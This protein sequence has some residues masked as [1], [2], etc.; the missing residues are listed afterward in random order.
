MDL[1]I[2]RIFDFCDLETQTK[3]TYCSKFTYQYLKRK[4]ER[5]VE[6]AKK[7]MLKIGDRFEVFDDEHVFFSDLYDSISTRCIIST[8]TFEELRKELKNKKIR[9]SQIRAM[10]LRVG[11]AI[12]KCRGIQLHKEFPK[13]EEFIYNCMAETIPCDDLISRLLRTKIITDI[14]K[15]CPLKIFRTSLVYYIR[16]SRFRS[17]EDAFYQLY[18]FKNLHKAQTLETIWFEMPSPLFWENFKHLLLELPKLPNLKCLSPVWFNVIKLYGA[19]E[20]N[21]SQDFRNSFLEDFHETLNTIKSQTT[22]EC[23]LKF[24]NSVKS[25]YP[26]YNEITFKI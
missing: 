9:Q 3:L 8:E 14:L 19:C 7:Y 5:E 20:Y 16:E 23:L 12:S 11:T 4:L 10:G 1:I 17:T 24:I 22:N 15:N 6:N 25:Y 26:R 18:V 13:I 2:E 21:F